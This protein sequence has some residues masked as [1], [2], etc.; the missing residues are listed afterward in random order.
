ML[1]NLV[2]VE[3]LGKPTKQ[4]GA[5]FAPVD[6]T[7]NVGIIRYVGEDLVGK[8]H[9]GQKVYVGNQREEVRMASADIMVMEEKNIIAIVEESDEQPQTQDS[10][11]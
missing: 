10:E 7:H 11:A 5:L 6:V 2:G 3:K 4:S 1:R 8:F 9:P